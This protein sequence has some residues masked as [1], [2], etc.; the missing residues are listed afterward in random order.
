MKFN[1]PLLVVKD[2]GLSRKFYEDVLNQEVILDFGENI[3][4]KGDFSLQS[5]QSWKK[6][7]SLSNESV[8]FGAKCYELYFEEDFFDDFLEKLSAYPITYVH[9]PVQYAWGQKVVRFYDLDKHIIEVGESM[10]SVVR[11]FYAQGLPAGEIAL[12]TQH[13][14]EFV[15]KCLTEK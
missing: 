12:R 13:P 8:T 10:A 1:C 7:I 4:F 6:F 2:L 14:L 15:E 3:T 5:L 9:E 11:R